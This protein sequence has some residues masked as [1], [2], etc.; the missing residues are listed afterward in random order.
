MLHT[1]KGAQTQTRSGWPRHTLYLW[2]CSPKPADSTCIATLIGGSKA[3][4]SC[5]QSCWLGTKLLCSHKPRGTRAA[6]LGSYHGAW[7][8]SQLTS[9]GSQH[10]L[11]QASASS[12][13]PQAGPSRRAQAR[14]KWQRHMHELEPL[15]RNVH[16]LLTLMETW[17]APEDIAPSEASS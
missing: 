5:S 3:G 11:S 13:Q 2:L 9:H 16:H 1:C 10:S 4:I 12:N 15:L 17:T 14:H 7:H 6:E 8:Y